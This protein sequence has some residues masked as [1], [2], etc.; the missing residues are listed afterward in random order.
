MKKVRSSLSP[1]PALGLW[2]VP[3][4]WEPLTATPPNS[5]ETHAFTAHW[6]LDSR[7][8]TLLSP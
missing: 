5:R 8:S 3:S 1:Y 4:G 7:L 2:S 6:N